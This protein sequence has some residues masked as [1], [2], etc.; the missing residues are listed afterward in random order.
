M[1]DNNDNRVEDSDFG[2]G[3]VLYD[4]S[5]WFIQSLTTKMNIP[6][7]RVPPTFVREKEG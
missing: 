3:I 5:L 4:K 7:Q 2:S 6:D 1:L